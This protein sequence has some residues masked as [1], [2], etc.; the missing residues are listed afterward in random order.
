MRGKTKRENVPSRHLRAPHRP[1]QRAEIPSL[2][3]SSPPLPGVYPIVHTGEGR[4]TAG[5]QSW[6]T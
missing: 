6:E 3:S 1:Q 5:K 2:L 4:W